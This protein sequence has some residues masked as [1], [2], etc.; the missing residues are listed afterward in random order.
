MR[1]DEAQLAS[2]TA[3]LLS[4]PVALPSAAVPLWWAALA[5]LSLAVP[6]PILLQAP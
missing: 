5:F 4:L 1:E 3:S 6:E 2:H